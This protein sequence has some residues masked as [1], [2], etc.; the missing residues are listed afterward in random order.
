MTGTVTKNTVR[1]ATILGLRTITQALSLVLVARLLGAEI[2]GG[3]VSAISL[4]LVLGILPTLG[5][6]YVMMALAPKRDDAVTYVWQYAWPL[7]LALGL[8][9]LGLYVPAVQM[10]S[11]ENT[12]PLGVLL[13]LGATDLLLTPM[14]SLV[15]FA[16]QAK[17][18]VPLSQIVQWLPIGFRALATIP[19]FSLLNEER[20]YGY[21]IWQFVA[22]AIGLFLSFAIVNRHCVLGWRPR[23]VTWSQ[24]R[25]GA[26]YTAM[27]FVAA[28]SSEVDKIFAG[29]L[30]SAYETGVYSATTR[31]ASALAMPVIAMLLSAQP[32]IFSH[33]HHPSRKGRR[34]IK[35][36]GVLAA[37]WG[38][39]SWF[40]LFL[41]SPLLPL[42]FGTSF[43]SM[44][45]LMPLLGS[46]TLPLC[47][48]HS[49]G[50]LL[51]ALGNPVARILIE[52]CG[53][54]IL[55]CGML[56]LT[57]SIGIQG[58]AIAMILSESSMA[59]IGWYSVLRRVR[60]TNDLD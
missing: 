47:L 25:N 23:L 30:V 15:S 16:L 41:G 54:V 29:R 10:V 1:T 13:W 2:Y 43:T 57:P 32:K 44:S 24:F 7:T 11:G 37:V 21:A 56:A 38:S 59:L 53:I 34:L 27:H 26:T 17:N 42:L 6:G 45:E 52:L 18:K 58:I 36:I 4:A 8:V 22:V 20:L 9:L 48:R 35:R 31:V 55:L 14:I 19:C 28:N 39:T 46:V 49:A 5:A 51:V 12:L 40:L 33:A 3:L 50:T 60:A